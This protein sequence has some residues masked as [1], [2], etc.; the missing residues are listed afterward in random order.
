[1]FHWEK[2]APIFCYVF[3]I[4]SRLLNPF[5]VQ[6]KSIL[7]GWDLW[8]SSN[9]PFSLHMNFVLPKGRIVLSAA[10]L[11]IG[12]NF[13]SLEDW[14]WPS[15][16][17][18]QNIGIQPANTC[19]GELSRGFF[20]LFWT[21]YCSRADLS[22]CKGKKETGNGADWC[23]EEGVFIH[24]WLHCLPPCLPPSVCNISSAITSHPCL[25]GCGSCSWVLQA[26]DVWLPCSQH[27]VVGRADTGRAGSQLWAKG[28]RESS[29][30]RLFR[31]Y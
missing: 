22:P 21:G 15:A 9:S 14:L 23:Q 17:W 20:C 6:E 2:C 18:P 16:P 30:T 29:L 8:A 12:I 13:G 31:S 25:G 27:Q 26:G 11:Q 24:T 28:V 7:Q 1:M 10:C 5:R 4:K 19:K 3:F